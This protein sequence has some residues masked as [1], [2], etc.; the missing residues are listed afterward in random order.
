MSSDIRSDPSPAPEV[1]PWRRPK[2]IALVASACALG[3]AAGLWA[4]PKL[5]VSSRAPEPMKP[6]STLPPGAAVQIV[7]APGEPPLEVVTP[8]RLEV[9][10]PD[11]AAAADAARVV[12]AAEPRTPPPPPIEVTPPDW[13]PPPRMAERPRPS[14]DCRYAR[15]RAEEMVCSDPELAAVDREMARAFRRAAESGV[16]YGD[17]RGEQD[18]WLSIREAAARRSPQAVASIYHQRIDELEAMAQDDW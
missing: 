18:D 15:S 7:I 17:L 14:F 4:T 11:M 16:P 8:G 1:P 3:L 10:P 12:V 6:V 2:V 9:L 5:A 13:G